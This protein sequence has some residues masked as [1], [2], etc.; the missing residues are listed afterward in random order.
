VIGQG[1]VVY[2]WNRNPEIRT[3]LVKTFSNR[4]IWLVDGPTVT[5]TGFRV[6]GGPY[7]ASE[8]LQDNP[9]ATREVSGPGKTSTE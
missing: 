2:A 4:T 8:L 6:S 1:A 5:G 7:T 3:A 9:P